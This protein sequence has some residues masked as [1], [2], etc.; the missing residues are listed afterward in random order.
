MHTPWIEMVTL[1][2]LNT[3]RPPF[4]LKNNIKKLSMKAFI[5][6]IPLKERDVN[7]GQK[8]GI[9]KIIY[10]ASRS[11]RDPGRKQTWS[12]IQSIIRSLFR[13][14]TINHKNYI[15]YS[16]A[17]FSHICCQNNLPDSIFRSIKNQFL[18][19]PKKKKELVKAQITREKEVK[20]EEKQGKERREVR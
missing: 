2:R 6:H 18:F 8:L 16:D 4:P 17:C 9:D 19:F 12:V 11:L 3:A 5:Y 7:K 13:F 20:Q 15:I 10:L 1:S 14:P